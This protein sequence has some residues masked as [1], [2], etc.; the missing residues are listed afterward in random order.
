M[1]EGVNADD[2]GDYRP[3]LRALEELAA[4][5]SPLLEAG[6]TKDEIRALS[7]QWGLPTWNKPAAACLS[8]RI[9][10]GQPVTA[11]KLAQVEQAEAVLREYADGPVR[12]RH[13]GD[14]ARIEAGDREVAR[15]VAPAAAADI[16]ARL[17]ALGFAYVA[18]DL[19]GYRASSMSRLL[20]KE[21]LNKHGR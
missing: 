20:D 1:L 14:L 19:A 9:A 4:M 2:T 3:G 13:H 18:V 5:R 6:L 8:S 21:T 12:V 16:T 15:L 11:V 17:K 10:Y 7:R